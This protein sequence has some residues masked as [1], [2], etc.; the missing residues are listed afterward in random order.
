MKPKIFIVEDDPAVRESL[1][2]VL[3]VNGYA[4]EESEDGGSLLSRGHYADLLCVIMD[5]NLPGENGLQI[6]KRLRDRAINVSVLIMSARSED[7]LRHEAE[8]LAA[9]AFLEKPVH[10]RALLA[11]L[12]SMRN[13]AVI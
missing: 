12:S 10:P 3:E 4:I 11:E 2:L 9:G 13:A 5:I 1:K 6:L 7:R 8:A